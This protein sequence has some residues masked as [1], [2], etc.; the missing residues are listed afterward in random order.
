MAR[1]SLEEENAFLRKRLDVFE[2]RLHQLEE[3]LSEEHTVVLREISREQA[4]KEIEEMFL[5]GET[6][7]Y[8]DIARKLRLD[9]EVVVEIC[10][11][12]MQKGQIE[13]SDH[14]V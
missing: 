5:Q 8:A 13:G 12:L 6:L 14:T 4:R 9:L 3:R 10:R 2:R 11:E 7:Y 1:I